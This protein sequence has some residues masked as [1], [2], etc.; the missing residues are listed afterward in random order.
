LKSK[1]DF[2]REFTDELLGMSIK[3]RT[4]LEERAYGMFIR[5]RQAKV[6]AVL[7]RM[8]AWLGSDKPVEPPKPDPPKPTPNGH[9]QAQQP[10]R[11]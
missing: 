7:E 4:E 2:I 10:V 6:R 11:K 1:D 3:P 8:H 5:E 9:P